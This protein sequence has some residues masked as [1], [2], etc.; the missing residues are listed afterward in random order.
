MLYVPDSGKVTN[1]SAVIRSANTTPLHR[2]ESKEPYAA[3]TIFRDVTV[4]RR[5]EEERLVQAEALEM[6]NQELLA[7][8]TE[9]EQRQK[10]FGDGDQLVARWRGRLSR[11][12]S[13]EGKFVEA[14][15]LIVESSKTAVPRCFRWSLRTAG[16]GVCQ[17][18]NTA[19]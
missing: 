1:V 11:L 4:A 15:A 7:A 6:Q 19:C 18:R 14:R 5:L 10:N 12:L 17:R 13:S 3:V 8:F 16:S 9:L 2:G